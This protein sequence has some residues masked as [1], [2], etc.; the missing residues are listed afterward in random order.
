M[1]GPFICSEHREAN[2]LEKKGSKRLPRASLLMIFQVLWDLS[3]MGIAPDLGNKLADTCWFDFVLFCGVFS[4]CKEPF[5]SLKKR[6]ERR[7]TNSSP[8]RKHYLART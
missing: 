3:H 4:I 5:L 8:G 6:H 2:P 7:E 1:Q